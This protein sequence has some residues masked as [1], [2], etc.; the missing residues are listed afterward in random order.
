MFGPTTGD[1]VRLGDTD[2]WIEVEKDYTV[3]GDECK[4]GGGELGHWFQYIHSLMIVPISRQNPARRT[5]SSV[6]PVRCRS[7]RPG[8]HQRPRHRL[9]GH[10]QGRHRGQ[11]QQDCGD[12]KGRKPRYDGQCDRGNDRWLEYRGERGQAY[13]VGHGAQISVIS[14]SLPERSSSSRQERLM[15]TSTTSALISGKRQV[16]S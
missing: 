14:R 12:R 8:H 11:E 10:L 2:L 5:R 3:Y 6:R 4:F 7:T 13:C 1:R 9:V 16:R 15:R